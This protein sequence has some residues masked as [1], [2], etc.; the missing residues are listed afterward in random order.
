MNLLKI[1][2]TK[3][4]FIK[5]QFHQCILTLSNGQQ[6]KVERRCTENYRDEVFE[7]AWQQAYDIIEGID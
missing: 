1:D 6:V 2:K 4:N 5:N 7:I 3:Y